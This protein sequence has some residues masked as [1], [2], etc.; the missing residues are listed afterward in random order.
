MVAPETPK[1]APEN[2]EP[3]YVPA[4]MDDAFN[5]VV[6]RFEFIIL[7]DVKFVPTR[8][9]EVKFV[10]YNAPEEILV[11]AIAIPETRSV[12]AVIFPIIILPQLN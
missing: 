4:L 8:F 7:V 2:K 3:T 1:D 5:D 12:F 10:E 11:D 9:V 6:L